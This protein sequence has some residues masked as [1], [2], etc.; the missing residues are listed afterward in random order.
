[1]VLFTA[2]LPLIG[3]VSLISIIYL[4]VFRTWN[5]FIERNVKFIRGIP[6][7]GSAYRAVVGLESPAISYQKCYE[8]YPSEQLIGI[9]DIGGRPQYLLRDPKLVA[10]LHTEHAAAFT[11]NHESRRIIKGDR[12]D[13]E[14]LHRLVAKCSKQFVEVIKESDRDVKLF[15]ARELFTRYANDVLAATAFGVERSSMREGGR[16]FLSIDDLMGQ[17]S[18]N[19]LISQSIRVLLQLINVPV[20]IERTAGSETK[21]DGKSKQTT[22]KDGK[23]LQANGQSCRKL[24]DVTEGKREFVIFFREYESFWGFSATFQE[25]GSF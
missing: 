7:I 21:A 6:L 8:R 14:Q 18:F 2:I 5:Y 22:R 1:M 15:D 16:D 10:Q 25:Y 3:A 19:R 20:S 11:S 12:M 4:F 23:H 24:S 9:Y 13:A 17:S